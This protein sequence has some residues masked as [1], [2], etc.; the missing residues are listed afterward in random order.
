MISERIGDFDSAK[1][2]YL[3]ALRLEHSSDNFF[4]V[5]LIAERMGDW[6]LSV[7]SLQKSLS[8]P[9]EHINPA[10]ALFRVF[11]E[12]KDYQAALNL[13]QELGWT[14][15]NMDYCVHQPPRINFETSAL[16]AML[17]HPDRAPCLLPIG[18][19]LTEDG[20]VTLARQVLLTVIEKSEN[21]NMRQEASAFLRRRLPMHDVVKLAESLNIVGY[22]LQY[23]FHA[24]APARVLYH[25][26]IAVDEKF[27]WP[28][29][30]I[31]ITYRDE[32]DLEHFY[33]WCGKAIA[34]NPNHWKAQFWFGT[35]AYRMK[36]W[37]EALAAYRKITE[38]D[39]TDGDGFS[40]M[41]RTLL[42]LGQ[43]TQAI[44]ALKEAVRLEPDRH[45]DQKLLKSL[46]E[47]EPR[48]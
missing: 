43:I 16:L 37:D 45:E 1:A 5:G 34:V 47:R 42:S 33:E 48:E 31:G 23:K 20:L 30:N 39:P 17:V 46:L 22:N 29:H 14:K 18:Q 38:L 21:E 15:P 28:Y 10:Q 13:A 40:G 44:Q 2:D 6:P 4:L 25:R 3:E 35:A 27:S 7:E 36:R 32:S 12:M 8:L 41:G 9:A 26:A 24:L 11:V 19:K